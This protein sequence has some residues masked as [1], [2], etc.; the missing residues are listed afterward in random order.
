MNSPQCSSH[1]AVLMLT[2]GQNYL[3]KYNSSTAKRLVLAEAAIVTTETLS[4]QTVGSPLHS[5]AW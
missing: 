5:N 4:T 2:V 1:K 3:S